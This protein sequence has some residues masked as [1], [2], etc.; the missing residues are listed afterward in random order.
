MEPGRRDL[1]LVD[2]RPVGRDYTRLLLEAPADWRSLPGQFVNILCE[3]D[4][5]SAI[6]SEGRPLDVG[7]S[8]EGG[9][10]EWPVAT[11]LELGRRWPVVR[12]PLS[13]SRV[14]VSGG[15][16][17]LSLLVRTV[18]TGT[19]FVASRPVGATLDVVGPLGKP[20]TP[21]PDGRLC[22]LVGGGC[23]VAPIFGLADY[24]HDLGNP[25]IGFF[26]AG[27]LEGLPLDFLQPP[28]ATE[29][30]IAMAQNVAEFADSGIPLVLATDDGTA[31]FRGTATAALEQYFRVAW[32]GEPVM[33]YGCG[34]EPML[35]AL[36]RLARERKLPCQV[37]LEGFMGCGIGVCL[38]CAR[39]RS[40]PASEKGWTLKLTCR[41]GP[42]VDADDFYL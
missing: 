4:G 31:G 16:L 33:L 36:V 12:R 21:P 9:A 8:A 19:L 18:G 32:L 41:D 15:R 23:G 39:K 26:G 30:R 7:D 2:R 42:V 20:F 22:I 6:A 29:H 38:S 14:V 28:E 37:S 25:V 24:L 35:R 17:Q 13:I 27:T 10:G 11:G 3:S 1:P 5:R 34:P 40:D